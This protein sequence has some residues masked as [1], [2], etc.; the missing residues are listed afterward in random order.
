MLS[1]EILTLQI[2]NRSANA[3]TALRM[4][5]VLLEY[6]VLVEAE[7]IFYYIDFPKP[8][9][10]FRMILFYF[11]YYYFFRT[12][13]DVYTHCKVEQFP[14]DDPHPISSIVIFH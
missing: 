10:N 2:V 9:F 7:D 5:R 11:F 8:T 1:C 13:L 3:V 12:I 6:V 4:R 14:Y